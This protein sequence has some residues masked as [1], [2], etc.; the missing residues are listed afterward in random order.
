MAF[1]KFFDVL[2]AASTLARHT[3]IELKIF[4]GCTFFKMPIDFSV[5]YF[6]TD[7]DYHYGV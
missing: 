2:F 1:T 3:K 6:L 4:K 7:A 5:R